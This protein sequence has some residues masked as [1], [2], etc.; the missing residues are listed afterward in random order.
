VRHLRAG[1]IAAQ[2]RHRLVGADA[3]QAA[4][5]PIPPEAACRWPGGREFLPPGAGRNVESELCAGRFRFLERTEAPGFPPRWELPELPRLWEYNLHYFEYLWAL[6]FESGRQLALSWIEEH[7]PDGPRVGWEPYPVSLRLENWCGYFFGRHGERLGGEPALRGRLW[8][9]IARQAE[10]L[11]RRLER[12]LLGNHLWE[13]AA[14]LAFVGG[15]FEGDAAA[16]W[17]RL[18]KE[19]LE[20]QLA[21]Q[22]LP[23]GVHFERSPMYHARLLY[24]LDLLAATGHPELVPALEAPRSRMRDALGQLCHPDGEIALLNDAAFGI[25]NPPGQLGAATPGDGVFAQPHAG[26]YGARSGDHYLVCDAGAIGPDYIPG[27]AHADIFGFELSLAGRR[28]IVDAGVRGYDG[29]PTRGWSRSTAAH[30]TV[31]IAGRDQCEMWGSFRVARRGRPRDVSWERSGD[32]FALE[33]WHDGYRRLP[34]RPVHRRRFRWHPDGVLMVR[35]RVEAG[36]EVPVAS[37]I[38]LHPDCRVEERLPGSVRVRHPG[39][40]FVVCV[41]GDASLDQEPSR[42]FPEFGVE[43]ESTALV[44]RARGTSLDLG[45]CVANGSEAVGYDLAAGARIAG[46][47]YTP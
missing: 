32:G 29:D 16:R 24:T 43:R 18:G 45:Y 23:D 22:L 11:S 9:S 2:L 39:G 1:Q 21:E 8:E 28:V 13:N 12:H 30:N 47:A 14:A 36:R 31:E 27:H 26:Y 6:P 20:A 15:C 19:L 34:G 35:D 40:A 33:G 38:H 41:A 37:R 4:S 10:W 17:R 3:R 44:L 46:R 5:L 7:A 42:Y 25:A